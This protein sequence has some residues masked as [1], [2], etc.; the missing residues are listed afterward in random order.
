[1]KLKLFFIVICVCVHFS[2]SFE[3]PVADADRS[4]SK[5][6]LKLMHD[7]LSNKTGQHQTANEEFRQ[8]YGHYQIEFTFVSKADGLL[9]V[10]NGKISVDFDLD[11]NFLNAFGNSIKKLSLVYSKI[12]IRSHGEFGKLVND[13]CHETLEEFKL[14]TAS[15]GNR[16]NML[17]PFKKVERVII[18]G[19]W[20]KGKL[21]F[22]ELFP[23]MRILNFTHD[24]QNFKMRHYSEYI[25]TN[26]YSNLFELNTFGRNPNDLEIFIQN[27]TQI[28]KLRVENTTVEF[29][30]LVNEKLSDLE[31]LAFN[32]PSDLAN[33]QEP[34]MQ[35]DTVNDLSVSDF[36]HFIRTGK[37]SFKNLK[38]IELSVGGNIK[39]EWISFIG[40]NKDL[41]ILRITSGVID[42]KTLLSLSK[43][44][45][46][47]LEAKVNCDKTVGVDSVIDFIE[48][49]EK[50][51]RIT[52]NMEQGS[53]EYL[54]DLSN[55]LENQWKITPID[56]SFSTLIAT[57][58]G[59]ADE[60]TIE[61]LEIIFEPVNN[62]ENMENISAQSIEGK[63]ETSG[64]N[65]QCQSETTGNNDGTHEP[66]DTLNFENE[67]GSPN[68][69]NPPNGTDN[70]SVDAPQNNENTGGGAVRIVSTTS[71][72]LAILTITAISLFI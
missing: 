61:D 33:Y 18:E 69:E 57:K 10:S 35:F 17:K 32:V 45:T 46:N 25:M 66:S 42:E 38:K 56:E 2:T 27:N 8:K 49:N 39:D 9:L 70:Q 60:E 36:H 34:T 23:E 29:L 11:S 40:S 4:E 53:T 41:E 37:L 22:N 19:F 24:P 55:R 30:K 7:A 64:G 21:S 26:H 58:C 62:E 67:E 5:N 44:L 15:V 31:T 65:S 12:S 13:H 48:N 14:R 3:E 59:D 52:L 1:M 20:R 47:L 72:I 68:T 51:K 50:L 6:L 63:P 43:N 71:S 54:E 28:K 16:D